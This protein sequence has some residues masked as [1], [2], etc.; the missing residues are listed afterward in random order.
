MCKARSVKQKITLH[1]FEPLSGLLQ[2]TLI[3]SW[4]NC[5]NQPKAIIFTGLLEVVLLK[6]SDPTF[7]PIRYASISQLLCKVFFLI[8]SSKLFWGDAARSI[9]NTSAYSCKSNFCTSARLLGAGCSIYYSLKHSF[10]LPI[11][12]Y[13]SQKSRCKCFWLLH[14]CLGL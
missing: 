9:P 11:N 7:E 8:F 3:F 2:E 14:L 13:F 5:K 6:R 10:P 4:N 12:S 1:P